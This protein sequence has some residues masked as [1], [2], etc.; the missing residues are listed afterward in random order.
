MY[1]KALR[2]VP[3]DPALLLSRSF[4]H[5]MSTPAR[6]DLALKDADAAIQYSPKAWQFW[7]QQGEMRLKIGDIQGAE[8]SLVNAVRFAQGF[9]KTIA[10]RSLADAR[11]R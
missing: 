9:N 3:S 2:I 1:D 10:Q 8:E 5:I 6:L 4:A 7:L 11:A